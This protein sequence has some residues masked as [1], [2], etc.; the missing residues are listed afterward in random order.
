MRAGLRCTGVASG[1]HLSLR[2]I[3]PQQRTL[4]L[5]DAVRDRVIVHVGAVVH[6]SATP[7]TDSSAESVLA[8]S[9]LLYSIDSR[10]HHARAVDPR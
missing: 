5:S 6:D 10:Q 8:P 2:S 7:A 3:T 4:S 9:Q 1:F